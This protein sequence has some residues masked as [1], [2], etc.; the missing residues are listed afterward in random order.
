MLDIRCAVEVDPFTDRVVVERTR[1]RE[2]ARLDVDRH[3]REEAVAAAVVEMQVGVDDGGDVAG[4]VL[5]VRCRAQIVDLG[6]RVDH[7]GVDEHEPLRVVDRPDEHGQALAVDEELCREVRA[8]HV[9]TLPPTAGPI[10]GAAADPE[11]KLRWAIDELHGDLR[12][13]GTYSPGGFETRPDWPL[14]G[15]GC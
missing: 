15:S 4:D 10:R 12:R 6:P 9:P 5:G 1:V 14:K 3:A 2:L 7:P 8:D 11:S 13:S